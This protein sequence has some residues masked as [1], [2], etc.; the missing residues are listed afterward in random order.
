M[1]LLRENEVHIDEVVPYLVDRTEPYLCRERDSR[2]YRVQVKPPDLAVL[3]KKMV[4][5]VHSLLTFVSQEIVDGVTAA[6]MRLVPVYEF[7]PTPRTGP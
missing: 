4:E 2:F 1:I 3:G 7:L 6:G 5:Q